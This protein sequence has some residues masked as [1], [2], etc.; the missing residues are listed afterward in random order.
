MMMMMIMMERRGLTGKHTHTQTEKMFIFYSF[1]GQFTTKNKKNK[2]ESEFSKQKK[3]ATKQFS[4][5]TVVINWKS[6]HLYFI[7]SPQTNI[8]FH[9]NILAFLPDFFFV[10]RL[11]WSLSQITIK[12]RK[13][14]QFSSKHLNRLF[15]CINK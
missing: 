8:S 12:H 1:S 13:N 7:F 11:F 10:F 3:Q 15:Q 4:A 6:N 5:K 2:N 9:L 14:D